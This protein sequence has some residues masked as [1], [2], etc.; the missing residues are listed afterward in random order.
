MRQ[1][2]LRRSLS[3]AGAA[4]RALA[5]SS[6]TEQADPGWPPAPVVVAAVCVRPVGQR[7]V[8]VDDVWHLRG[9]DEPDREIERIDSAQARQH[10]AQRA[11]HG[12]G[13][14]A[15]TRT[16]TGGDSYPGRRKRSTRRTP[17]R[18]SP[19]WRGGDPG[20]Q[21]LTVLGLPAPA[22]RH[23]APRPSRHPS[24]GQPP[25]AVASAEDPVVLPQRNRG[26]QRWT[27]CPGA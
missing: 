23:R 21:L 15:T 4:A 22:S 25:R 12:M 11:V 24:R 16:E 9:A 7:R 10:T 17:G 13:L 6:R 5:G 3:R 27:N 18:A 8:P 2:H 26:R 1:R 19:A 14:S 20:Q